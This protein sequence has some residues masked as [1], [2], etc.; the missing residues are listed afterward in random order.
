VVRCFQFALR[1]KKDDLSLE[2]NDP[3]VVR[4]NAIIIIITKDNHN[5]WT[6]MTSQQTLV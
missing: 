1:P 4:L 3:S 2:E 6:Q 5:H